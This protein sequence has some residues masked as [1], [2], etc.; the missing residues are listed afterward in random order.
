MAPPQIV[1]RLPIA[2]LISF[3]ELQVASGRAVLTGV[4]P[5]EPGHTAYLGLGAGEEVLFWIGARVTRS[6]PDP[7]GFE[8]QVGVLTAEQQALLA[9]LK[10]RVAAPAEP[11]PKRAAAARPVPTLAPIEAIEVPDL[12][13]ADLDPEP[14][15]DPGVAPGGQTKFGNMLNPSYLD[16]LEDAE[17]AMDHGRYDEAIGIYESL[18]RTTTP[19]RVVSSGIEVAQGLRAIAAGELEAGIAHLERAL[20][21]NPRCQRAERKLREL[22]RR[23]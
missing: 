20:D 18:E 1:L 7:P 21:V 17:T 16:Q 6:I 2:E 19:A 8:L 23:A 14:K 12:P 13:G 9:S 10:R 3:I 22:G 11:A 4:P 15:T 5:V